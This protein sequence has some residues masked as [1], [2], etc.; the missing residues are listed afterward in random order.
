MANLT[1]CDDVHATLGKGNEVL[2]LFE[3]YSE[4]GGLPKLEAFKLTQGGPLPLLASEVCRPKS[5]GV[6]V[7]GFVSHYEL[8][9]RGSILLTSQN[10]HV[11]ILYVKFVSPH[12]QKFI[13]LR[14]GFAEFDYV[15]SD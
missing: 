14:V 6:N 5:V 11:G 8:L 13:I 4:N 7:N 9:V 10:V 1:E 2:V 3:S 12:R 15:E